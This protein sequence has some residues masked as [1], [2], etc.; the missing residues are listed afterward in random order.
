[1]WLN[2]ERLD[3]FTVFYQWCCEGNTKLI[4]KLKKL[5]NNLVQVEII[6]TPKGQIQ[7]TH[8]KNVVTRLAAEESDLKD[9]EFF[10]LFMGLGA[11]T[12]YKALNELASSMPVNTIVSVYALGY[13]HGKPQEKLE[14]Y[15]KSLGF[16]RSQE[17]SADDRYSSDETGVTMK[18]T[19]GEVLRVLHDKVAK[20]PLYLK[21][22]FYTSKVT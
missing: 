11:V 6:I 21:S 9:D 17:V 3:E 15:Y 22:E 20:H 19:L 7:L 5:C 16:N 14:L 4:K 1:M 2:I 8:F 13:F 10:S 18:S 12:L